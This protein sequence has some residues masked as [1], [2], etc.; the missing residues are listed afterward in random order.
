MKKLSKIFLIIGGIGAA[1]VTIGLIVCGIVFIYVSKSVS[2]EVL[3]EAFKSMLETIEGASEADKLAVLRA[4]LLGGAIGILISALFS[5][6]ATVLAFVCCKKESKTICIPTI[7]LGFLAGNLFIG[8]G[9]IF[10]LVAANNEQRQ[11][12]SSY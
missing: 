1:L 5:L 7:I 12:Q 3:K 9:G 4:G 2:D 10:A 8:L 11:N 6:V